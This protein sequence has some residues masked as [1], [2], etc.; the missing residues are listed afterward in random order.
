MHL[1][2]I[3]I[4]FS[5]LCHTSFSTPQSLKAPHFTWICSILPVLIQKYFYD[6]QMEVHETS[7]TCGTHIDDRYT[8]HLEIYALTGYYVAYN[9]NS[10]PMFRET[11]RSLIQISR[12]PSWNYRLEDWTDRLSRNVCKE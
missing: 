10:L 9:G 12:Y 1:R 8:D 6:C 3:I 11:Y 7:G 4:K 5:R 2:P